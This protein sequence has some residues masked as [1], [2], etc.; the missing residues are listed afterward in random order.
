MIDEVIM[1]SVHQPIRKHDAKSSKDRERT[2]RIMTMTA[3]DLLIDEFA[4][5]TSPKT[6]SG[7]PE[8]YER[9]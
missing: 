5:L 6:N 2:A 1:L 4:T 7:S 8:E 3:S 9:P